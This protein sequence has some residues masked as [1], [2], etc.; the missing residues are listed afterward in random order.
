MANIDGFPD[1]PVAG[2]DYI[3]KML[4]QFIQYGNPIQF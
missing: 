2:S 4:E 3:D 1:N